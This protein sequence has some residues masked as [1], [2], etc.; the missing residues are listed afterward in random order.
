MV[1]HWL[2]ILKQC[3]R[4]CLCFVL[5]DFNFKANRLAHLKIRIRRNPQCVRRAMERKFFAC[6]EGTVKIYAQKGLQTPAE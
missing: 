4:S 5:S 2:L 3:G 1:L 6:V